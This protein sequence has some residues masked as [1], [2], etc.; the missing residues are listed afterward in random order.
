MVLQFYL[1]F[2]SRH[3]GFLVKNGLDGSRNL[4]RT[5]PHDVNRSQNIVRTSPCVLIS[6]GSPV[7]IPCDFLHTLL[8]YNAVRMKPNKN[9]FMY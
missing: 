5:C 1:K 4:I 7:L 3:Y 2:P 6:S 9:H 8:N